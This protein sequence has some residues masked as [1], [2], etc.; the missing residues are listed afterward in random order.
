MKDIKQ[1]I[2][3]MTGK[4]IVMVVILGV[5][6]F[7]GSRV[8]SNKN[9]PVAQVQNQDQEAVVEPT[10]TMPAVLAETKSVTAQ[11]TAVIPNNTVTATKSV[12][13]VSQTSPVSPKSAQR[14]EGLA[15]IRIGA[16]LMENWDADVEN[17]GPVLDIVYLDNQGEILN[18]Y[19]T[20]KM[21]ITA[22]VKLYAGSDPLSK[23]D[24]LVYSQHFDSNQIIFGGIYPRIRIPKEKINVNPATD[25][26]Y[27]ATEVTIHTPNQGDFSATGILIT[28]YE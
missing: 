3:T 12:P 26:K 13:I 18:T 28:L 16:G 24:K 14:V 21:P 1:F 17:D 4:I 15:T 9:E 7:I 10:Q 8:L 20:Q 6:M 2:E 22:D 27:G 25:Y 5:G 11:K 19:E 23:K